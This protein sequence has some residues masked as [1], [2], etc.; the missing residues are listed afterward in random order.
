MS[1]YRDLIELVLQ[2]KYPGQLVIQL[3]DHCNACCPQ[4]GMSI[5]HPYKRSRLR[6]DDVKR[7]LDAAAKKGIKVVSF[8][9]GEPLLMVDELTMFMKYAGDAGIDYIR[10]GTNGFIFMNHEKSGFFSR[11]HRIA[12]KLAETPLRNFWISID[13]AI[14]SVHEAMRGFPG[15]IAGIRKALPIF[16][17]HGIYPTA[18]AFVNRK[19]GGEE[20]ALPIIPQHDQARL[21]VFY[22]RYGKA[23]DDL[24][25][26][27][28][29]LGF[30]MVSTCYPISVAENNDAADMKPIYGATSSESLV[31][32]SNDEKAVLFKALLENVT[33][34][35]PKIRA[36]SPHCSLYALHKQYLNDAESSAYPCR[37]G[38]DF[39][40][41]DAK[42]GCTYPCGYRGKENLGKFWN[43]NTALIDSGFPCYR[44]D[45]ECFR[46]PSEF[47]G[48]LIHGMN[49]PL[50]LLKKLSRDKRYLA[51]WAE[52]LLYYS[53]CSFFDGRRPPD[54]LRLQRFEKQS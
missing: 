29:E 16:H 25:R 34:W 7:T 45:W 23:L 42:D 26:F 14:S 22:D 15:V 52:D 51:S 10:T 8:T 18:N 33:E 30:T 19:V 39:F 11:I 38:I 27:V 31:R 49:N 43:L 32:F 47:F 20:T 40:F 3:T 5:T 6:N 13:S 46:D 28:V 48:P 1:V 36:F 12:E 50:G 4:C 54:Y 35:R 21:K 37:G 24:F 41:I 17:Q 53:A 44:C 2:R 9:G